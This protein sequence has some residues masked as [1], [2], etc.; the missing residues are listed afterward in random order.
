[1][2]KG[3]PRYEKAGA[4]LGV[5]RAVGFLDSYIQTLLGVE[6]ELRMEFGADGWRQLL[7]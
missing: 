7:A 3:S 6:E 5:P 4:G 1:V 2:G